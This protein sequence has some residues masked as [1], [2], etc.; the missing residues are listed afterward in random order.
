MDISLFW[1]Y[2]AENAMIIPAAV[3]A[4]LPVRSALKHNKVHT[5]LSDM[6]Y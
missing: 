6:L 1:R 3:S 4:V 5:A 2:T